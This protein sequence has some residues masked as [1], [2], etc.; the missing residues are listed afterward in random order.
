MLHESMRVRPGSLCLMPEFGT[1][2]VHM[3]TF[4]GSF[5]GG[6]RRLNWDQGDASARII[7]AWK[8]HF[9]MFLKCNVQTRA[10]SRCLPT[11]WLAL[12]CLWVV[13]FALH[14]SLQWARL[15]WKSSVISSASSFIKDSWH[16]GPFSEMRCPDHSPPPKNAAS[17]HIKQSGYFL[18]STVSNNG[19]YTQVH[20]H[21]KN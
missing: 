2:F 6:L 14:H 19:T 12:V 9:T 10:S 16:L 20:S 3:N 8:S 5:T 1:S 13:P 4:S 7:Q 11:L 18:G 17:P 21:F 15:C